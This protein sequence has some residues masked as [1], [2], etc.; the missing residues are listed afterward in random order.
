MIKKISIIVAGILMA[1]SV[2]SNAQRNPY[3]EMDVINRSNGTI[4]DLANVRGVSVEEFKKS[5]GLPEDMPADTNETIALEFVP[6]KYFATAN[7]MSV[8]E[9]VG[10]YNMILEDVNENS[11]MKDI[12][13]KLTVGDS[14]LGDDYGID[15]FRSD[16]GIDI[17]IN[18]DTPYRVVENYINRSILSASGI[19]SYY[20]N[21]DILV[22]VK[23]KYIDFDV[24]PVVENDRVLVPMRNIFTALGAEVYWQ[25]DVQTVIAVRNGDTIAMQLGQ[26]YL[27]KNNERIE[28][29]TASIAKDGRILVPIRAVAEALDTE[30]FYNS[31]TKTVVIH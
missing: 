8:E 5:W 3:N 7:G 19:L 28:I 18:E 29:P 11:L 6:L 25:G 13:D 17:D 27:F 24:A 15:E 22:M 30:V 2:C 4:E 20:G 26:N 21:D 23:G 12:K 31:N 1:T 9:A 16:L 10:G 14:F